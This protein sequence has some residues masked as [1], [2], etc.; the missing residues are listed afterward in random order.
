MTEQDSGN[1]MQP[2]EGGSTRQVLSVGEQLAAAR[3]ARGWAVEDVAAQLNLAP[4]QVVAIEHDNHAALPGMPITRGFIRAY[5]KLLKIEAAPLMASLGGEVAGPV[6]TAAPRK[7]VA[8]P[9]AES[10]MP[11]L[12]ERKR[13]ALPV[14][15]I[16]VVL[17]LGASGYW[18]FQNQGLLP[19]LATPDTGSETSEQAPAAASAPEASAPALPPADQ[20]TPAASADSVTP[21][22]DTVLT[23]PQIPPAAPAPSVTT[24]Q[25]SDVGSPAQPSPETGATT[26]AVPT[27]GQASGPAQSVPSD[28]LV[29]N[30]REETWVEI[31]RANGNSVVLSRLLRVGESQTVTVT[32][33]LTLVIG[34]AGGVNLTLR[35]E[36]L[37]IKGGSGNVSKITVK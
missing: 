32:E 18:L 29:L 22:A 1:H 15:A 10:R 9:F 28:A 7:V 33:P 4:R 5:A 19:N 21:P 30:A 13:S 36:P 24:A 2:D 27:P 37:S 6:E 20:G 16:V 11:T 17:V 31:R 3:Q 25:P 14:V 26:A 35:G 8:A 34:N 12:G 23:N